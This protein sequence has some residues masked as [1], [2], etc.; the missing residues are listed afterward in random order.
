[1]TRRAFAGKQELTPPPARL[2]QR[3]NLSPSSPHGPYEFFAKRNQFHVVHAKRPCRRT[4]N[5]GNAR[6]SKGRAFATKSPAN[7]GLFNFQG[8]YIV[9]RAS[10]V[11]TAFVSTANICTFA[12]V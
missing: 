12:R 9:K 5:T 6:T 7:A 8:L 11:N 3:A 2:D 10:A 1:M 4:G